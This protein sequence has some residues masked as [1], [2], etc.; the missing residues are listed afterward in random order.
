MDSSILLSSRGP[1]ATAEKATVTM[2]TMTENAT[3][4]LFKMEWT[5]R[6]SHYRYSH[7]HERYS[8]ILIVLLLKHSNITNPCVNIRTMLLC[9]LQL[10]HN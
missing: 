5:L 9:P 6:R 1:D 4:E 7:Y 2:D 3:A 8:D 10:R